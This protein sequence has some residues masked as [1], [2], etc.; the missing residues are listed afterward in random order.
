MGEKAYFKAEMRAY[1][2]LSTQDML[3]NADSFA[4]FV[5]YVQSEVPQ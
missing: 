2:M 3:D 1:N 4:Q 5:R